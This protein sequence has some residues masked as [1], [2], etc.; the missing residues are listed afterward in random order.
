MNRYNV[1]RMQD[2]SPK[3]VEGEITVQQ[4]LSEVKKIESGIQRIWQISAVEVVSCSD[5]E[6][7]LSG[8]AYQANFSLDNIPCRGIC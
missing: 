1:C 2:M 4:F 7:K 3:P 8:Y 5:V 6:A